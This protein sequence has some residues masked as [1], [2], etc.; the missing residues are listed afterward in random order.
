MTKQRMLEGCDGVLQHI[1]AQ[2]AGYPVLSVHVLQPVEAVVDVRIVQVI[3]QVLPSRILEI[4]TVEEQMFVRQFPFQNIV[5]TSTV[6]K[7]ATELAI[8]TVLVPTRNSQSSECK[9]HFT[10]ERHEITASRAS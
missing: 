5:E 10:M 2:S 4:Q 7:L 3:A 8:P 1:V 6:E 9:S